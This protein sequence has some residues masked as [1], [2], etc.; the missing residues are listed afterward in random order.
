VS[1]PTVSTLN[2][3]DWVPFLVAARLTRRSAHCAQVGAFAP[4]NVN[5][6]EF[7]VVADRVYVCAEPIGVDAPL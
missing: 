2:V 3:E 4:E 1:G 5:V 6:C 7:V